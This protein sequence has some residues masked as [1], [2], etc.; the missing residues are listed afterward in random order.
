MYISKG[1]QAQLEGW[2][3]DKAWPHALSRGFR[4]MPGSQLHVISTSIISK[5][6]TF[7]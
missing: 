4:A 1:H 6:D 3:E 7:Q 2:R 5:K